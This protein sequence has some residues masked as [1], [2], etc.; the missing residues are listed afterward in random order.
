MSGYTYDTGA[1]IAAERDDWRMRRIHQLAIGQSS[2][3][4]VPAGVLAEAWRGGPQPRLSRLLKSCDIEPLT[5]T[6]A[7][8]VGALIARSGLPDPVDVAVVEGAVRRRDAAIVTSNPTHIRQV[9]ESMG[10]HIEILEV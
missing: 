2:A 5:E 8:A 9:L 6:Q 7:R 4:T 1:L 10:A 3:P